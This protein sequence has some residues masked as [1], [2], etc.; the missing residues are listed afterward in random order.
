MDV[1]QYQITAKRNDSVM[2]FGVQAEGPGHAVIKG[3]EILAGQKGWHIKATFIGPPR[4]REGYSEYY[5]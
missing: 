5:D 1:M 3:C 4:Y 2:V